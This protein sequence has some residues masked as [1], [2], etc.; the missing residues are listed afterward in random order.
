MRNLA[1]LILAGLVAA[2]PLAGSAQ[3]VSGIRPLQVIVH[4]DH[5]SL[6]PAE[7]S[8]LD[9][10]AEIEGFLE[11]LDSHPP[12]WAA[13]YGP[14]GH[15]H[16][17]RLFLLN[18]ERDRLREGHPALRARVTF[19]WP[20]ELSD[21]DPFQGGFRVAVGPKAIATSWGLVRFKPQDLPSPMV[22]VPSPSARE[23]LRRKRAQDLRI[24]VT[25]AVTGRLVPQESLI[26][27]FA[28]EEAGR[29]M[30]MPVVRIERLDYFLYGSS[31]TQ[32]NPVPLGRSSGYP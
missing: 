30:V 3:V 2:S 7:A 32:R 21:Y 23:V 11:V 15:D 10:P 14:E 25:V 27:D 31:L 29:G 19:L 24:E 28:H 5:R 1:A 6:L 22:A 12:D 18:R 26:Y 8:L 4:G 9:Q 16:D 20:G 13:F 17:E